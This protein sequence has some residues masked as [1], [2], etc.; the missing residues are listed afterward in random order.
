MERLLHWTAALSILLILLVLGSVRRAHIRVEYSVAWLAASLGLLILS[1]SP[2]LLE[3]AADAFGL[4]YPPVA[5][6][7]ISGAAFLLV[8]FRISVII[9]KLK[10]DNIALAQ[11]L[12]IVE[13]YLRNGRGPHQ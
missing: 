9:S 13:F 12:A 4:T 6:L 10:D 8:F 5:L 3:W 2:A 11:R 7:L 1:L